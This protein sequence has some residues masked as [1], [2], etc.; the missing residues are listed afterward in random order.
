[1]LVLM[2]KLNAVLQQ[3]SPNFFYVMYLTTLVRRS[4]I[5]DHIFDNLPTVSAPKEFALDEELSRYLANPPEN[6]LWWIYPRFSIW[7]EIKYLPGW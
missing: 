3:T 6:H 5:P 7:S 4:L 1:M 2:S